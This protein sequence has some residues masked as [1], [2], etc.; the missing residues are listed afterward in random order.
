MIL[1]IAP[2]PTIE[3]EQEGMM[4][5]IRTVDRIFE[6][7]KRTYAHISLYNSEED[8]ISK[9]LSIY[10]LNFNNNIDIKKLRDLILKANLIYVHSI[11]NGQ[12]ILPFYKYK[13]IITDMHGVVPEE[14]AYAGRTKFAEYLEKI[15]K[16]IVHNSHLI[17]NVSKT[18][19][20]HLKNKYP[21]IKTE[22]TVLPIID[23]YQINIDKRKKISKKKR[24]TAIY[25]GGTQKWQNTDLMIEAIAKAKDKFKFI[26]LTKD[27]NQVREKINRYKLNDIVEIKSMTRNEI[28]E[29]YY[30]ADFGFILRDDI[31]INRVA[32]PTKLTEYLAYGII[33]IVIQ[34]EIGDFNASGY[35]YITLNDFVNGNIPCEDK[36]ENLRNNNY[37]VIDRLMQEFNNSV[38][39]ILN[40]NTHSS[41]NNN[42]DIYLTVDEIKNHYCKA[43]LYIDTGSGFSEDQS[44][45]KEI[46][47]KNE[48]LEFNLSN[49]N[50]ITSLRF[51]PLNNL[52][53]I[54]L[55][56]IKILDVNNK[57]HTD[58]YY[59]SNSI[60][61]KDSIL[62]FDTLDPQIYIDTSSIP[63]PIKLF[64]KL[65]YICQGNDVSKCISEYRKKEIN[66][67]QEIIKNKDT[68]IDNLIHKYFS[69]LFI[70]NGSGF[71]EDLSIIKKISGDEKKLV[72]DLLNYNNIEA[73]RFAPLN[74]SVKIKLEQI[75]IIDSNNLYNH[76]IYRHNGL[77]TQDNTLTFET[78]APGIYIDI[79]D[80][81]NPQKIIIYIEYIL[82]GDKTHKDISENKSAIIQTRD[83]EIQTRDREIQTR[84][85][86]IQTQKIKIEKLL[87]K[88]HILN[89]IYNSHGWK[90]LLIYYKLR[91]FILPE[92]SLRRKLICSILKIPG[93]LKKKL[94]PVNMSCDI[95]DIYP[96]FTDIS[97]WALSP[98]GMEKV[99]IFL[100]GRLLGNVVYGK[101]RTDVGKVFPDIK[102]ST[103]SGFQLKEKTDKT[104]PA[105]T[106][107][108]I[109]I[110]ATDKKG[111]KKETT[112]SAITREFIPIPVNENPC[113]KVSEKNEFIPP[114]ANKNHYEEW[115]VKNEPDESELEKQKHIK[116]TYE[117]KIS[118]LILNKDIINSILNQS[119]F[120]I[121]LYM[122]D[123]IE[124]R[125]FLKDNRVKILRVKNTDSDIFKEFLYQ[126]EG[127]FITFISPAYI[128]C[129]FALYETVKILQENR[130]IDFIYSD[131]DSITEEGKRYAP[132]FKPDFS[133]DT[134]RST[135]YIGPCVTVKKELLNQ[136]DC[137][138]ETFHGGDF[139]D[140]VFKSTE[141]AQNIVHIPKV[142]FHKKP[143]RY[144]WS[145][146]IK[147]M[148]KNILLKEYT[149]P[150]KKSLYK[151]SLIILN[152][153]RPEY[154][155]T[156]LKSLIN[157]NCG[158]YYEIIVGDTGSTDKKILDY[159]ET[160]TSKIKIVKNLTYNFSSNYNYLINN[161]SEGEIAGIINNDIILP[162][163]EFLYKIEKLLSEKTAGA[164]GTKLLYSD[165][166]LQHG[167][168]YFMEE[169]K[170]KGLPYHRLHGGDPLKLPSVEYEKIPAVTGAFMF[171]RRDDFINVGNFDEHYKEEAQDVDLCMK[172][173][174]KGKE[175]FFLNT[176]GI[177]H[178]ENGTRA[179]GSENWDDR[180]YFLWKWM[181]FLE[182]TIMG[183]KINHI[184]LNS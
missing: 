85:R 64:I 68:Q 74:N 158:T 42:S 67:L 49:Y 76:V 141:K 37:R 182:G 71:T 5:R 103:Y 148:K 168:I 44:I 45:S 12:Y 94:N 2:Y 126:A 78:D 119:Y 95:A 137:L 113:E 171:C 117:P 46:S 150:S 13:K 30:R 91:D 116:F 10:N 27:F 111:R 135:N 60:Y 174:R 26:I 51:D 161:Y 14:E 3:N 56:E 17:I 55:E 124:N 162:D 110:I 118:I 134:L 140:L 48:L 156:L 160:I 105:G 69:Q 24:I 138:L 80:I 20:E 62:M 115:I 59:E 29:Y 108:T 9:E 179:K 170:Y 79:K 180:E 1:F 133:P 31:V 72:F 144:R 61:K 114:A 120:N 127:E 129:T 125:E 93:Y 145:V 8:F 16:F 173:R 152:K 151:F 75:N 163:T 122:V 89:N 154:L 77:F 139:Y 100:D 147:E 32:C 65:E 70:N 101:E 63:E 132:Y 28:D 86:E 82:M 43:Q 58:I 178:L 81:V 34:P 130:N 109:K 23:N 39:R 169:G 22:M 53:K 54:K 183:K 99:E 33:P 165:G 52:I 146:N 164:V 166:R 106:A 181:S 157:K 40:I 38:K 41:C 97:G 15:E 7:E 142:L 131:E 177:I 83:R 184:L 172:L 128:P 176:D 136:I 92:N 84:D 36:I 87:E 155:I 90:F 25:S 121:E 4:Q 18:M 66:V 73:L 107:H 19:S 153:N 21:D 35:S 50:N 102:N 149:V 88:E 98:E 11:Y 6:N 47:E 175:I 143:Y 167:G 123:D 159:Y 104:Y 112:V 96:E 57:L